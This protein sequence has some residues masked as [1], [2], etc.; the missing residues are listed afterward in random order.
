MPHAVAD[1][2]PAVVRRLKLPDPQ[3]V[4]G[5]TERWT[6]G[7]LIDTILTRDPWMHRMDISRATERTPELSADHDGV[8]VADV[9]AEWAERHGRP[10]RL[11]LTGPA[12][13]DFT[14]GSEGPELT[15]DAV[16]FCRALSGRPAR[17]P[18]AHDLFDVAV[19]F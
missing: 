18:T 15:L 3:D 1:G 17:L 2:R 4:N 10:Y 8:L 13:G 19:P 11:H 12:G 6:N 7:Y 16:D 5:R 14:A 9:V